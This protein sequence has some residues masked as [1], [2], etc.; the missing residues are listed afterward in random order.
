MCL[1]LLNPNLDALDDGRD[2]PTLDQLTA[3][4]RSKQKDKS[5]LQKTIES[6][7]LDLAEQEA[8]KPTPPS[9]SSSQ[10]QSTTSDASSTIDPA[11]S[12]LE[13]EAEGEGA[14]N[15]V[16]GEINWDCPC[17]G[18]MAYGPCGEE[19][20]TAFSCFVY[21]TE[22]P[23]GM[24]CI[25]KFQG[26]QDCF[27]AHPEV[28]AGELEDENSEEL[29]DALAKEVEEYKG[30][31]D[32]RRTRDAASESGSGSLLDDVKE[33]VS[34]AVEGVKQS[35][36]AKTGSVKKQKKEDSGAQK[37]KQSN[38][39]APQKTSGDQPV[40]AAKTTSHTPSEFSQ[41]KE[42]QYGAGSQVT[43]QRQAPETSA[44]ATPESEALVPKA[45]HDATT[46]TIEDQEGGKKSKA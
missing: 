19:F 45:A 18:G 1:D 28:Y 17:L 42:S 20:R 43:P 12:D 16:T 31:V 15:P 7:S 8:Q 34:G 27:R 46:E 36:G 23:K 9:S 37:S 21:S 6:S 38:Q 33:E 35:L 14:F 40:P 4:S 25:E 10:S 5:T 44:D 26:M 24:D 39:D 2:H 13:Q 3:S 41:E 22:E 11:A 30:K 29:D 32:E